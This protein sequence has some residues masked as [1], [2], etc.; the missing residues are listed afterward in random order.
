MRKLIF[1]IFLSLLSVQSHA[2]EPAVGECSAMPS[3][4]LVE[5]SQAVNWVSSCVYTEE[6]GGPAPADPYWNEISRRFY[7]ETREQGTCSVSQIYRRSWYYE[8]VEDTDNSCTS[9]PCFNGV[10]DGAE[11]GVD[12]GGTCSAPCEPICG[13]SEWLVEWGGSTQCEGRVMPNNYG[14]CPDGAILMANGK[15]AY[16]RD[17]DLQA[18]TV[19][20]PENS[21][22]DNPDLPVASEQDTSTTVETV[23]NQDGTSTQTET[24]I[25]Q[26]PDGTITQTEKTTII[27]NT[28]GDTIQQTIIVQSTTPN[29]SSNNDIVSSVDSNTVQVH[30]LE[31]TLKNEQ[32]ATRDKIAAESQANRDHLEAQLEVDPEYNNGLGLPAANYYDGTLDP[33]DVPDESDIQSLITN[34]V[35]SYPLFS[36]LDTWQVT[37]FETKCSIDSEQPIYGEILTIDFCKW[38]PY[39]EPF[40][41]L[42]VLF[43]QVYSILIVLGKAKLG[44]GTD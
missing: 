12:C 19:L 2:E 38:G 8:F 28:T 3:G 31:T 25:T 10:Q 42:L 44:G 6:F 43:T 23:D 26:I 35:S 11:I 15:C 34:F 30:T 33:A 22:P 13:D 40:G 32:Q 14:L 17:P 27:D 16:W 29:D 24:T 39:L 36:I 20:P 4:E 9:E 7:F 1:T 18:S 41:A 21:P 37:T 5:Y